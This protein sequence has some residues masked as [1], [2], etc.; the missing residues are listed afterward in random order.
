MDNFF[1]LV[2]GAVFIVLACLLIFYLQ[3]QQ[4]FV[5]IR[6]ELHVIQQQTLSKLP[7]ETLKRDMA[8]H[9]DKL[10]L[11]EAEISKY[12]RESLTEDELKTFLTSR[13][14]IQ[15]HIASLKANGHWVGIPFEFEWT[16]LSDRLP[17]LVGL[18]RKYEAERAAET[19]AKEPV[20]E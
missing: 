5:E 13:N 19:A 3:T 10:V 15:K 11:L 4:S 6:E 17:N 1:L 9:H 14:Q 8:M 7:A 18:Y 20:T 2:S 12:H 16:E